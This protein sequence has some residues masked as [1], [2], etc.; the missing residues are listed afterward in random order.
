[1][2]RI[3]ADGC[4]PLANAACVAAGGQVIQVRHKTLL[5]TSL[6]SGRW[7]DPGHGG[8]GR[9][10]PAARRALS[11]AGQEILRRPAPGPPVPVRARHSQ[12]RHGT[13]LHDRPGPAQRPRGR[14]RL[15]PFAGLGLRCWLLG[16]PAGTGWATLR[17]V[18]KLWLGFAPRQVVAVP[19]ARTA[20]GLGRGLAGS[21]GPAPNR[22]RDYFGLTG[23]ASP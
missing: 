16:V 22:P 13:H 15:R 7:N 3:T 6:C 5:P 20:P 19:G 12:R 8:G 21:R 14:G 23:K 11:Q 4:K 9:A 17:A 2:D 10:G 1:V 18:L